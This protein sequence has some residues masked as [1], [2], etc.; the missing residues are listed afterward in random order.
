MAFDITQI[1]ETLRL[2]VIITTILDTISSWMTANTFMLIIF[3]FLWIAILV[4]VLATLIHQGIK[5]KW[6]WFWA[7]LLLAIFT[8]LTLVIFIIAIY[9]I[10]WWTGAI[11]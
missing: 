9:W 5:K 4:I 6:G 11:K 2:N 10:L 7:T 3:M 8:G 1:M